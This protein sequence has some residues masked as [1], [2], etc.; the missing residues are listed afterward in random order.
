MQSTRQRRSQR[1]IAEI[2]CGLMNIYLKKP[3][4]IL[5][6]LLIIYSN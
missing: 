3:E 2:Y 5:S 4:D 1:E 6:D